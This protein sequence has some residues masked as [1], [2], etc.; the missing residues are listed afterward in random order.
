MFEAAELGRQVSKE[1]YQRLAPPLRVELLQ[2]QFDLREA[3]FPVLLLI[4]GD[5]RQGANEVFNLF[6]EWLDARLLDA[7]AFGR[8]SDEERERPAFWR[9]WRKLPPKGRIGIF[10]GGWT[11]NTIGLRLREHIDDVRLERYLRHIRNLEKALVDDGTL[12]VKFWLHLPEQEF[13][14]RQ[15]RNKKA[16]ESFWGFDNSDGLDSQGYKATR[17]L[18][19]KVLRR[20]SAQVPWNLVEST[21]RRYR[22]LKIAQVFHTALQ[23]RLA[24]RPPEPPPERSE[25]IT[26]DATTILDTVD[27]GCSIPDKSEYERRLERAQTEAHRLGFEARRKGVS[28]MLVFE[29]WDAAGKG[30]IIRRLTWALDATGYRVIQISAPSE[31]E[32]AHHYL[33]RF[34]NKV[35]PAGRMSIFDRSWYGRV[36]V[37][38]VEGYARDEEWMR[39]YAEINDFEEQLTSHGIVLL[40]FWLHI[41]ADEQLRRFEAREATPFKKFKITAEDYRNRAR[42]KDYELAANEMIERTSTEYAPWT[43]IAAND[44]RWARVAVLEAFAAALARAIG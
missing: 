29:G 32:R 6:H 39:A 3:N 22:D 13:K 42:W 27:L 4:A 15:R 12:V 38:R 34:W 17:T 33:W 36:L 9:Y 44:K 30:G 2:R 1:E 5:D 10:L 14:R 31:E 40:K 35:P 18:I 20:T 25:P 28:T 7:F 21:D 23:K 26:Y 19:E 43:L 24:Q 37:E 16:R 41:D 11:S 8:R